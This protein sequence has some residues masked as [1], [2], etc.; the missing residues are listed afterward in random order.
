MLCSQ[1]VGKVLSAG[2]VALSVEQPWENWGRKPG[3]SIVVL[4]HL[5]CLTEPRQTLGLNSRCAVTSWKEG[6]A[7]LHQ[8]VPR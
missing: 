4:R 8:K 1:R 7:A 2:D 6:S 3:Y 5:W